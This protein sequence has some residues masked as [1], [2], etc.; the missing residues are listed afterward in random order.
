MVKP[1]CRRDRIIGHPESNYTIMAHSEHAAINRN[2]DG[3]WT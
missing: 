3:L 2:L 1:V